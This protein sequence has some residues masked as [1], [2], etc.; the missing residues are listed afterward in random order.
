MILVMDEATANIDSHTEMRIQKAMQRLLEG[1]TGL[2]IAHRLATVRNADRIIVLKE[3]E[4]LEQGDHASLIKLGGL[5][6]GLCQLNYSSFDDVIN[7]KVA[8]SNQ[9]ILT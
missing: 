5:Y 8:S 1:R 3:G 2:V 4:L 9:P 7:S 6:A